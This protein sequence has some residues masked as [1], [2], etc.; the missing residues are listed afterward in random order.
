MVC[1]N[2]FFFDLL[3]KI[4]IIVI[5]NLTHPHPNPIPTPTPAECNTSRFFLAANPNRYDSQSQYEG[6]FSV[7]LAVSYFTFTSNHVMY[8]VSLLSTLNQWKFKE[9]SGFFH[10]NDAVILLY[11]PHKSRSIEF[12]KTVGAALIKIAKD[13]SKDLPYVICIR[14]DPEENGIDVCQGDIDELNQLLSSED[15]ILKTLFLTVKSRA[16]IAVKFLHAVKLAIEAKARN[17]S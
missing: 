7:G 10:F 6:L 3:L 12:L 8:N 4:I 17:E 5:I 11:E 2:F 1:Y 13:R 9:P 14:M 16:D 15:D